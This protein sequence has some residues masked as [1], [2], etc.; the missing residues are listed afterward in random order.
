MK[1]KI[2]IAGAGGIG[3]AVALIISEFNIFQAD[4]AFGDV[5]QQALDDALYFVKE[6]SSHSVKLEGFLMDKGGNYENLVP[7]LNECDVLLDCLPGSLAPKMAELARTCG[8]HYAN[9]TEYVSETNQIK[10]IADGA[11]TSFV[12][13]TGLA[14][15][16]INILA[17]KLY[18]QFKEKYGNDM[19]EEMTMKVGALPQNAC[20]PHFYAFTWS[21]IGV[22]TEYLKN[23]VIVDNY[24]Q[25]EVAALSDTESLIINGDRFEDNYTSGGAANLPEAFSGKIRKLHYK[26]LRQ[27]GHYQWVK[28]QLETIPEGLNKISTLEKMMLEN[29]PSVENDMVVIYASVEGFD[30]HGRRRKIEKA[31]K[32]LPT[33][34]GKRPLRAIQTTTAAPMCEMAYMMLSKKWKGLMQQSDVPTSEFLNGPF[35]SRIYGS[36]EEH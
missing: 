18:E 27:P 30:N 15:G 35:V 13:Q 17:C 19:L 8:C 14:P 28:R 32:I 21:P 10:A 6:G 9:L 12:L 7:V 22:A 1:A 3:Q 36:F 26:T 5:S 4:I 29:I 23:A 16:F 11:N 20:H 2:F 34:V 33:L 31:Y 25:T 24:K